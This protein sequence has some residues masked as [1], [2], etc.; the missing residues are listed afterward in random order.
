MEKFIDIVDLEFSY[1]ETDGGRKI[2]ILDGVNLEI[3]QGEFLTILGHNGSGKSTLAK[4]LNA[5]LTPTAGDVF[6]RGINTKD[7]SRLYDIRS[8]VGLVFQNPDNQIVASIVED[9]V[10]FGPENLGIAPEEIRARVDDAL[11]AVDMYDCRKDAIYN[12]SGGQKQRVAIAGIIAMRPSCLVLDEPTAMLDPVGR[13]EVMR[14]I[15]KLNK[16][17][18]ITIVLITHYM[19]EATDSDR[20][21]VMSKGK[22]AR[23]GAPLSIFSDV[24]FLKKCQ[25]SIPQSVELLQKLKAHGAN[26]PSFAL[27][28]TECVD[29]LAQCFSVNAIR[30]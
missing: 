8:T 13:E 18:G 20:I 27:N 4:H 23:I 5:M 2:N 3:K 6:V 19:D 22:I 28:E 11:R 25:L 7:S 21:V 1:E 30:R 12:L 17:C 29:V 10:A 16:E 24:D 15:K 14:V 26:V 9:D